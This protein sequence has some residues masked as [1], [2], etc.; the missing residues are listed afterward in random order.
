MAAPG[1]GLALAAVGGQRDVELAAASLAV[2]EVVE[3]GAALGDG[4]PQHGDGRPGEAVPARG[5][6]AAPGARRMDAGG[7]ESLAGVDVAE[8]DGDA[9]VPEESLH[10]SAPPGGLPPHTLPPAPPAPRPPTPTPPA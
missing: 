2:G 4:A 3:R 6:D 5:T 8:A 9:G 10:R 7:E 1:A